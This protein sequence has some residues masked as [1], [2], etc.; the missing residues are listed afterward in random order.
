MPTLIKEFTDG[1]LLEYDRGGFDNWCVYLS[2]PGRPRYAPK[3]TQYFTELKTI[4]E[5]FSAKNVYAD[6]VEI[7]AATGKQIETQVLD[8]IGALCKKYNADALEVE[9]IFVIFYAAMVAEENKAY[10]RLGKRVKR[11]GLYQVLFDGMEPRQAADYSKGKP[12][13][14]IAAEC[15]KRGF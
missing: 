9:I 14:D 7:Y 13:R 2:R 6:F 12:W 1:S 11:L 4:A 8:K 3:D 15:K 5:K 10:T